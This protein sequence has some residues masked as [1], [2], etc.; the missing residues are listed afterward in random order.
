VHALYYQPDEPQSLAMT[1]TRALADKER[2][3]KM[4]IAAREHVLKYH[5]RPQPVADA[6]IRMALGYE[7][8]PG[9]VVLD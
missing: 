9:G 6:L 7:E 2:L 4:A 5:V 1:I 8:A 3:H